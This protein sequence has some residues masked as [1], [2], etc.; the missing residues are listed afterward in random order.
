MNENTN[1]PGVIVAR[2]KPGPAT[3]QPTK[4]PATQRRKKN[5]QP[6]KGEISGPDLLRTSKVVLRRR[7]A[8]AVVVLVVS[9]AI[10]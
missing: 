3:H 1:N 10:G 5:Q 6:S 9:E 7:V 8:R 4:T 2:T